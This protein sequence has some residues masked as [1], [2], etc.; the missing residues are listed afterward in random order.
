MKTLLILRHAK[1]SWSDPKVADRER[2]LNPRGRRDAPRLGELIKQLGLDPDVIISSDA[3]RAQLTAE[4]AAAAMSFAGEVQ[5][6]R[7]LYLADPDEIIAVLRAV[8]PPSAAKVMVVGHNPGLEQLI[9]RLTDEPHE[10]PTAALAQIVLPIDRWR[11]LTLTTAGKLAGLWHPR[12][13][14][15]DGS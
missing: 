4:T 15:E 14:L 1:S 13:L 7:A 6:E 2:T 8:E 9:E 11:D 3:L 12:E 5:L 10:L